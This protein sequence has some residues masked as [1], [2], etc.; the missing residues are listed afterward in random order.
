MHPPQGY[1]HLLQTRRLT[2]TSRKMVLRL[3]KYLHGMKQSS[4]IWYGTFKHFGI[5]MGFVT[6]RVDG[7]LFLLHTKDQEI[8]AP[9]VL[10][11]DDLLIIAN[12]ELIGQIKDHMKKRFRMHDLGS[13]SFYL[14]MNIEP[15]R[16][17][18]TIDIHQHSHIRTILAKFRMDK[19]RPVV[20]PMAIKL[21]KRKPDEEACDLTICQSMIGSLM[22]AMTATRADIEYGIGVLSRY[23][24]DLSNKDM[25]A[26]KQVFQYLNS[27]KNWRLGFG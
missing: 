27:T 18:Y 7:G 13:V 23:N 9:V 6:S 11:V 26:L 10:Y 21:Y 1:F 3:K 5:S 14:S 19:S 17:H 8:V 20:T 25:V 24:H 2:K 22:Y 12:E 15:N 4:H 16:E